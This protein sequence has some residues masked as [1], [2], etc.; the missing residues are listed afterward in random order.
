[1][2][3][4]SKQ[5]IGRGPEASQAA[6]FLCEGEDRGMRRSEGGRGGAVWGRGSGFLCNTSRLVC[7]FT[8]GMWY[9][10]CLRFSEILCK[11]ERKKVGR[12]KVLCTGT[13]LVSAQNLRELTKILAYRVCLFWKL[14]N[15]AAVA[16]GR[17]ALLS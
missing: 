6:G 1:M 9:L 11:S 12:R 13:K 7:F 4:E 8:D 16:R 2:R 14:E 15:R 3:Q 10:P 5:T 17:P